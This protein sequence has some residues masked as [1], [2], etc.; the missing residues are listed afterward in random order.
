MSKQ[1]DLAVRLNVLGAQMARFRVEFYPDTDSAYAGT[2]GAAV[3]LAV[4]DWARQVREI[5]MDLRERARERRNGV[6]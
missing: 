1:R 3:I 6:M 5:E 4:Q 2:K